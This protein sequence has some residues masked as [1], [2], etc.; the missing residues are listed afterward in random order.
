MLNVLFGCWMALWRRSFGSDGFG[1]PVLKIR[2]V[3]H[4]IGFLGACIALWACDYAWWQIIACVSV[5]Q[6]L[7]WA[8]AVGP[9][10]DAGRSKNIDVERYKKEYWNK[11]CEF[12]VPQSAWYGYFYDYLWMFFRYEIPAVLISIILLNP[13]FLLTGFLVAMCYSFGWAM[14]ENKKTKMIGSQIAEVLSG[15]IT[16]FLLTL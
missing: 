10:L 8:R 9:A 1:L 4:I 15:F 12:L 3:Q 2:A 16:G 13:F 6:G 7:F 11:W 5:L 14:Y